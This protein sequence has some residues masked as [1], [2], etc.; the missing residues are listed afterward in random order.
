MKKGI[1]ITILFVILLSSLTASVFA[2]PMANV[3]N[4]TQT[5]EAEIEKSRILLLEKALES[6]EPYAAAKTWAE[7]VKTR[8][9]ALQYA[10]MSPNLKNK[11]YSDFVGTGWVTGVSS[12]WV[13]SYEVAEKYRLNNDTYRFEVVFTY[14]DSTKS[15]F[16]IKKHVTVNNFNGSWLISAIEEVDI[17][18]EITQLTIDEDN[19]IKRIFIEDISAETGNY[20]KANVIVGSDTKIYEGF[21]DNE[22]SVNDLKEGT[23]VIVTFTNHPRIMIYPISAKAKII[24]V[25]ENDILPDSIELKYENIELKN[26]AMLDDLSALEEKLE[27]RKVENIN[28]ENLVLSLYS[29]SYNKVSGVFKPGDSQFV[30]NDL[31][32]SHDVASIKLYNLQVNYENHGNRIYLLAAIGSDILGYK[33]VFY[34]ETNGEWLFYHNWGAP[35]VTDINNDG[36]SEVLMQFEG[37]HNNAADGNILTFNKG[38][39]MVCGI[40]SW[41]YEKTGLS[42]DATIVFSKFRQQDENVLV[43]IELFRDM[44]MR[45]SY[46]FSGDSLETLRSVQTD[47][48]VFENTQYGFRFK[49]PGSWSNFT[50]VAEQWE[51]LSIGGSTEDK[52]VETGHVI[53]IRHPLWTAQSP[54]QDIPIMIFSIDQWDLLKKEKFHIGAAPVGPKEIGRNGK[55]VFAL[56]A[57]YNYAFLT[58]FEEVERILESMETDA[59]VVNVY[60]A[61]SKKEPGGLYPVDREVRRDEDPVKAA[62]EEMLKGPSE[63]EK[64]LGYMSRFS[65]QT[66]GMLNNIKR[67]EDGETLIIDFAD[68]RKLFDRSKVPSP[69]SFGPGGIMADITWT[70]FKQF[71][72]VNALRFS[73]EGDESAFWSWLAGEQHEPETFTRTDWE[74]I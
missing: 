37:L 42:N 57:R 12:P 3:S 13:E 25:M 34:N 54:R 71:P 27:D 11:Y 9:G 20:D 30:L 1:F 56:P 59:Q 10:V 63:E 52:I 2:N 44:R 58:G 51:G 72:D 4:K 36:T 48:I 18:G 64:K 50:V 23:N 17:N 40:N 69:T 15:Y 45:K 66:A 33:Y 35:I 21:T 24:R 32:Y 41:V 39:F 65:A 22:L 16:S 8:N 62:L 47:S 49:M 53:N 19:S 46:S 5:G 60:F 7:G 67:S 38:K 28:E 31:G 29:D 73:F 74:N 43:D 68:F 61:C 14:T 6:K 26:I 70:I 55:Y